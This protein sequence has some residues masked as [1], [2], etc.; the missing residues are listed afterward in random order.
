[1]LGPGGVGAAGHASGSGSGTG[2]QKSMGGVKLLSAQE[3]K[4]QHQR[5]Q[6]A[7]KQS[8]GQQEIMGGVKLLSAKELK[9]QRQRDQVSKKNSTDRLGQPPRGTGTTLGQAS[10]AG[11]A[12]D[13]LSKAEALSIINRNVKE[14]DVAGVGWWLYSVSPELGSYVAAFKQSRIDGPKLLKLS[15]LDMQAM[16]MRQQH[17]E[18]IIE[19][20]TDLLVSN[21]L[22]KAR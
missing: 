1:M 17:R 13:N 6:V 4:K 19:A 7:K 11:G 3:L 5:E 22:A 16:G 20:R 14:A 21:A 12:A 15:D 8:T 18:A 2:Q 9:Q 10:K